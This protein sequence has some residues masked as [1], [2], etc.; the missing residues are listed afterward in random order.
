MTLALHP[1]TP[2]DLIRNLIIADI[3][4]LRGR[5]SPEMP[6]YVDALLDIERSGR[7]KTKKEAFAALE[8]FEK[9][10]IAKTSEEQPLKFCAISFAVGSTYTA[11]P[12]H[13]YRPEQ[14]Q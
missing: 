13:E 11:I 3:S 12:A 10:S 5:L 8:P 14:R 4:P 2:K 6:K 7:C 9:V 1:D